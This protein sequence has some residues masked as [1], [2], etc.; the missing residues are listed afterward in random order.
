MKK[1]YECFGWSVA[2]ANIRHFTLHVKLAIDQRCRFSCTKCH[3]RLVVHANRKIKV[4]D[5]PASGYPVIIEAEVFH[6]RCPHC[7][8][9]HTLRP[10]TIHPSMKFTLRLIREVSRLMRR[11]PAKQ[12]ARDY[13][14]S[15][16]SALRM[17]RWVLSQEMPQPCMDGVDAI[18]V[19]E[20]YLGASHGYITLV[21]S[22]KS[23]EPLFMGKGR[24]GECLEAFFMSLTQEQRQGILYLGIDRSNTYRSV[25]LRCL[26]NVKICY[27][28]YHLVSNMNGV[29]DDVRR[30]V[31]TQ[32]TKDKD[33]ALKKVVE[34][35]RYLLLSAPQKLD[36]PGRLRLDQLFAINRKLN[37]TYMLKEQ[38]RA[39]FRQREENAAM[40]G[41]IDWIRMATASKVKRLVD[42]ALGIRNKFNEI[43]NSFRYHINS[44]RIESM[45]AEINRIQAR[46][47]GLFDLRYLFLKLR[48]S[49]FLRAVPFYVKPIPPHQQ[50]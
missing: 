47:C 45:N 41:L 26:P 50:N 14:I 20:K 10:S 39:I 18:I 17:D 16:S 37:V 22:A 25:A 1:I 4:R 24:N 30:G 9:Y 38:F 32:A 28:P 23:G 12:V 11:A 15:L 40:L 21:L 29:V 31:M 13:G 3:T 33:D 8:S 19:D 27:D 44:A 49:Y 36:A 7:G 48:Q 42:F 35:T 5:L 2:E 34:N 43:I 6:G 46:C